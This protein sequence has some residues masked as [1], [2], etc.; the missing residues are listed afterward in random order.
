MK[1]VFSVMP[2]FPFILKSYIYSRTCL[3]NFPIFL[4]KHTK[5]V[6]KYIHLKDDFAHTELFPDV[7]D[8]EFLN[9]RI[10]C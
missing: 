2:T 10:T 7:L 8:S 4:N 6:L 1:F 5:E 3:Q 9:K